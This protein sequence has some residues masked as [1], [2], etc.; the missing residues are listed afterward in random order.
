M[1]T[2]LHIIGLAATLAAALV[3]SFLGILALAK[4]AFDI[5]LASR[6]EP[7]DLSSQDESGANWRRPP[8]RFKTAANFLA[9]LAASAFLFWL[10]Y[11]LA[12]WGLAPGR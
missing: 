10:S 4:L 3:C 5:W 1:A 8:D 9:L 2:A 11:A 7:F 6:R 12:R